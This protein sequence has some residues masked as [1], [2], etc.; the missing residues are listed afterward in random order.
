MKEEE[1]MDVAV[2]ER[3]NCSSTTNSQ[4]TKEGAL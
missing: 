4:A 2:R 3:S 1:E